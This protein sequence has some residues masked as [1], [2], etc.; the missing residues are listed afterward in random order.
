M[1]KYI[2]L[3]VIL[4]STFVLVG[5]DKLSISGQQ[6]FQIVSN[7]NARIDTFLLDTQKGKVWRMVKITDL[8]GQPTIWEPMEI[9]DPDG[10]IGITPKT[11][12]ERYPP[13]KKNK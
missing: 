9:I 11:L 4:F 13:V 8:E 10:E 5:C 1:K 3:P 6:R 2:F 12:L 7:P